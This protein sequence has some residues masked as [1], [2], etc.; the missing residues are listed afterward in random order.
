MGINLVRGKDN[1]GKKIKSYAKQ[2]ATTK[3]KAKLAHKKYE[4]MDN[5]RRKAHQKAKGK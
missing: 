3:K 1:M 5:E 4:R 2:F